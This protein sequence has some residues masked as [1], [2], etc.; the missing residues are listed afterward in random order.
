M[1]SISLIHI[2]SQR[3]R[4]P[5]KESWTP[6]EAYE[7]QMGD[8][9]SSARGNFS[10]KIL[11]RMAYDK[12]LKQ[13][14]EIA[15]RISFNQYNNT[16][17]A[18]GITI[19]TNKCSFFDNVPNV[20][21]FD[22]DDTIACFCTGP[23]VYTF[24]LPLHLSIIKEVILLN[25]KILKV[26]FDLKD[27]DHIINTFDVQHK[28]NTTLLECIHEKFGLRFDAESDIAYNAV[29]IWKLYQKCFNPNNTVYYS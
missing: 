4:I 11:K 21:A 13:F 16:V 20:V 10:K 18:P 8:R 14:P 7:I 17:I 22:C 27:N 1:N 28:A 6:S 3:S 15:G 29:W 24:S 23:Q 9:N 5:I 2:F 26:V 25:K 19:Y 12:M